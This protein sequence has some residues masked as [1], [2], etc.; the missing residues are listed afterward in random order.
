MV[1]YNGAMIDIDNVLD[2]LKKGEKLLEDFEKKVD[3]LSQERGKTMIFEFTYVA[4]GMT[5]KLHSIYFYLTL[6]QKIKF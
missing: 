1:M 6:F 4:Y 3:E 5:Y 2:R